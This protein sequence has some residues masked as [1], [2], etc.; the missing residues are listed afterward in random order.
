MGE[1]RRAASFPLPLNSHLG[2]RFNTQKRRSAR[3][4]FFSGNLSS[5]RC[6]KHP[7]SIFLPPF[8][9]PPPPSSF[10]PTA[11]RK[12]Y[13]HFPFFSPPRQTEMVC[14]RSRPW[15]FSPFPP[16]FLFSPSTRNP[17]AIFFSALPGR[18]WMYQSTPDPSLF[19]SVMVKRE[20][21]WKPLTTTPL[22]PPP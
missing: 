11:G 22:F 1:W 5:S 15:D 6:G 10:R 17:R 4:H 14:T 13:T 16:F 18:Q 2:R 20:V 21:A 3:R 12:A 9:P 19:P 8:H 7:P